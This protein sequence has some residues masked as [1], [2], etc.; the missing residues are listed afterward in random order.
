MTPTI[1]GD[2]IQDDTAGIQARL[3][4]R[5]ALVALP[6][7]AANYLIS[8]P[9]VLHSNQTL[10]LDR[11]ALIRLAPASSCLMLM[12]DDAD[13]GNENVSVEGGIWDMDNVRQ[14]ENPIVKLIRA[15]KQQNQRVAYD[16]AR[17]LGICMRF[18]NVRNFRMASLTFRDPV[19][20]CTQF[21]KLTHFV[22]DDITFDFQHWNP[23]PYNMDGIHLDG[24][25]RF[26][27]ITNLHGATYDDLIALNADDLEGESPFHGPIEDIT[28]DGIY[29]RDCHS[30][31]RLL[32]TC[33][34]V[35]RINVSNVYGTFFMYAIGFT[36]W[37]HHRQTEGC[38]DAI[39]LRNVQMAKAPRYPHYMRDRVPE[40]PVIWFEKGTRTRNLRID[41]FHRCE[42]ATAI[43]TIRVDAGATIESLVLTNP[44]C[45][46]SVAAGF[47]LLVNHGTIEKLTL[48]AALEDGGPGRQIEDQGRIGQR[49]SY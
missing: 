22:I 13:G 3:D 17:Y 14:E 30:G 15:V 33:S 20:F 36:K 26:G 35:R 46:S 41:D 21:A 38:F 9:L 27:R 11:F 1:Y 7:P 6:T 18:V 28:I 47:P 5:Q 12:N 8:R 31:I 49:K 45:L 40:F 4:Q 48:L 24:G 39:T 2:G 16:P 44:S 37:A 23:H 19:T 43:E 10:K 29:C 42:E 25:C 34:P 32:S